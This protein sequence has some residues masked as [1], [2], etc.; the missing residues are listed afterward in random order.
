MLPSLFTVPFLKFHVLGGA[1]FSLSLESILEVG[2]PMVTCRI[3]YKSK[4][5]LNVSVGEL[6]KSDERGTVGCLK[7]P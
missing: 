2:S 6:L 4:A 3:K 5:Y 1:F 7:C